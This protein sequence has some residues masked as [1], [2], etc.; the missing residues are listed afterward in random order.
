MA[1]WLGPLITGAF[2]LVVALIEL[3]ASKERK[4]EKQAREEA[5][6]E[7][8]HDRALN[9]GVLALLRNSIIGQYNHYMEQG[10]IRI[11]ALENALSMYEAYHS[12]GGNG[13]VT[14]LVDALRELPTEPPHET[15]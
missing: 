10:Y 1:A 8:E 11:Y 14:K 4:D 2:T 9:D 6:K 13:T 15:T 5:A 12:L 3:R 7:R